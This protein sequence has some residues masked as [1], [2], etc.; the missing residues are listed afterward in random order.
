MAQHKV[1]DVFPETTDHMCTTQRNTSKSSMHTVSFA[2][3][4]S[5]YNKK[6]TQPAQNQNSKKPIEEIITWYQDEI[7][8]LCEQFRQPN[9]SSDLDIL[10]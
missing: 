4:Q 3:S 2:F 5:P 9:P 6:D 10:H 7:I 1:H 8:N